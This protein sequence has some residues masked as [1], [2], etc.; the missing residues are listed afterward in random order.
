MAQGGGGGHWCHTCV[1][2]GRHQV[3]IQAQA[4]GIFFIVKQL[5]NFEALVRV[6]DRVHVQ[7]PVHH[8]PR[9]KRDAVYFCSLLSH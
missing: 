3:M 8:G 1:H 7:S 5:G 9:D 4:L 6:R 2:L